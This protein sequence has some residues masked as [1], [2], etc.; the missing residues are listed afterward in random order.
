MPFR[1]TPGPGGF[2]P[3]PA[4]GH[5][6]QG[7]RLQPA[8]THAVPGVYEG[9]AVTGSHLWLLALALLAVIAAA[10]VAIRRRRR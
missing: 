2:G 3:S 5:A 7:I 10:T 9:P 6:H 4:F 8:Q 1:S